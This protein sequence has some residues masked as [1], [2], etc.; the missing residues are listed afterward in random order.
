VN[1]LDPGRG[2]VVDRLVGS[3]VV[4][5]VDVVEGLQLDVFDVAPRTFGADQL[6]L[7]ELDLGLSQSVV[8]G[9]TDRPD[10]GIDAGRSGASRTPGSGVRADSRTSTN[11]WLSSTPSHRSPSCE[12]HDSSRMNLVTGVSSFQQGT[13]SQGE[14]LRLPMERTREPVLGLTD[15]RLLRGIGSRN[16][17]IIRV[18]RVTSWLA[19]TPMSGVGPGQGRFRQVLPRSGEVWSRLSRNEK[20]WGSNPVVPKRVTSG[21]LSKLP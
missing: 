7:V 14:C 17:E 18:V 3:L 12:P 9:I 10:R 19:R 8:I 11:T 1:F 13:H 15:P 16:S 2:E 4:E 21:L 6:G 20:A 5:P